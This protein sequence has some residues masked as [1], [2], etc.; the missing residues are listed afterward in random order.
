METVTQHTLLALPGQGYWT[1]VRD[2][3]ALAFWLYRR[4]YSYTRYKDGRR[5]RHGYRNRFLIAGPGE[6][7]VLL[8]IDGQA[9]CCWR[10]FHDDFSDETR[11]FCSVFRN[12]ST[13]RASTILREAMALAWQR[14][15]GE[16]LWTYVDPQK[17][18]S[19]VP[20]YCFRRAGWWRDGETAGGLLVFAVDPPS[21]IPQRHEL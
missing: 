4:H 6:K 13:H 12:E 3:N 1:K 21:G 11:V 5:D 14:W 9:L 20:G 2:G 18:R 8:G 7:I 15:P 10:R 19:A 17:V 16:R